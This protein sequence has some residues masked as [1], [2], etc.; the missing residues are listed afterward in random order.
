MEPIIQTPAEFFKE[1]YE[2]TRTFVL[3]EI[4]PPGPRRIMLFIT[5]TVYAICMHIAYHRCASQCGM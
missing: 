2:K 3:E 5:P 4:I 1:L